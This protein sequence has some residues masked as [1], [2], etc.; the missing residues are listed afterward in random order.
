[1]SRDNNGKNFCFQMAARQRR[2][3]NEQVPS[4][5]PLAP[6]VQELMAQQNEILRQLLQRQ[7]HPQQYG[8]GQLQRSLAAATYQE[9]LSTQ[10]PLFTKAEDPLDADVW[11]R[12][13]ESKFPLLTGACPDDTKVRF[14][15]QQ[16]RGPAMTW[17]DHFCAM[18]PADH[19]VTWE[20]FNTAFRG[21][22]IPAGILDRKLNGFLALTQ[23]TRTVLQYA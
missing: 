15:A 4:P 5:L 9:F 19:V 3:Q 23:G 16:L 22:H 20:E 13:V 10:P 11:L 12:V 2:G 8:G 6:T 21:H 14:A 17:W 18:L 7:P 1:M